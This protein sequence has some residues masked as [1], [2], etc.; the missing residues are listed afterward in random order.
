MRSAEP[1]HRTISG[2]ISG[3]VSPIVPGTISL[4]CVPDMRPHADYVGRQIFGNVLSDGLQN[5]LCDHPRGRNGVAKKSFV[6]VS[7]PFWQRELPLA[8]SLTLTGRDREA[9]LKSGTGAIK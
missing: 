3:T 2:A 4:Q 8:D 1:G 6:F 9:N 7:L 5:A